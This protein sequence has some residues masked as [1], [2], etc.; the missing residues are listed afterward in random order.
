M[1]ISKSETAAIGIAS[2]IVSSMAI[3]LGAL[4]TV[5]ALPTPNGDIMISR[6]LLRFLKVCI[7]QRRGGVLYKSTQRR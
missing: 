7:G 2:L 1:Q 4:A 3:S 5:H 6:F